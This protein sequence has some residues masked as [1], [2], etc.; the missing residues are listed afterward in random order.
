MLTGSLQIKNDKYY[1]MLNLYVNGKRK[2]K[3]IPL[4]L[5]V[6]G[7]KRA[8]ELELCKLIT[9]YENENNAQKLPEGANVLL[10]DYLHQWLEM[11][12]PTIALATYQSYKNMVNARLDRYFR[13]LGVTLGGVTPTQIQTFY[14]TILDDGYTTNTVI[15]YHAVLRRA[16]Q[17]AVKK[18]IIP[19]NPA[20]RV[21]KPKK[22]S[23][24]ASFYSDGEMQELFNV[25]DNDPLCLPVKIAAYYGLRR[26]EV[27]GL[28]WDAINFAE[29]SISIHHKVIE[30]QVDGKF[31]PYGEDVLKT[32]AS[33]RTLPLLPVIEKL[34]LEEKEKQETFRRLFKKDHCKQYLDYICVDQMGNLL[35]PNFVTEHF[36]YMVDKFNLKKIRFHDLR[37]T[38][39]SLL[40]ANGVPMKQIQI[41]LGH[42]NFSTTADIYA[43]LDVSAQ[44]ETGDVAGTFYTKSE[45]KYP[46]PIA[47]SQGGEKKSDEPAAGEDS[48]N[49]GTPSKPCHRVKQAAPEPTV[50]QAEGTVQ[51]KPCRAKKPSSKPS[52]VPQSSEKKGSRPRTTSRGVET[53]P[54]KT[55][56]QSGSAGRCRKPKE[57]Q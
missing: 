53:C 41:W 12:K 17:N 46:E 52:A 29:K 31:V 42:S 57:L 27:L 25:F 32:K 48:S 8:A 33:I 9:K 38:C 23:Y 55:S 26:S 36:S 44:T 54:R 16:L 40:L 11:A 19:R 2:P 14:Q 13:D 21:D 5:P 49:D 34:L 20:D 47:I 35:R 50:D 56:S 43:H 15:H 6:R 22:N 28:K 10:A 30:V 39:A 4:G 18:D 51:R 24:K 7:N 1:A 45:K 3:W 37:H